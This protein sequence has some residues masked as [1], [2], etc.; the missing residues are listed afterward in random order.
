MTWASIV[1]ALVF[2][3]TGSL[4]L[5][6][7]KPRRRRDLLERVTTSTMPP[8]ACRSM[9]ITETV[10]VAAIPM[11]MRSLFPVPTGPQTR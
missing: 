7:L 11:S 9:T 8:A 5:V 1:T 4:V 2:Y 3:L 10:G 6:L